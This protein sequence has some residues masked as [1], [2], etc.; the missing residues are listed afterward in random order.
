[1]EFFQN[2]I[3]E[4]DIIIYQDIGP[5][6]V[7]AVNFNNKQYFYNPEDWKVEESYKAYSPQMKVH[8]TKEFAKNL[9]GRIWIIDTKDTCL[10]DELFDK[11]EYEEIINKEFITNYYEEYL[12]KIKLIKK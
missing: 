3:Q 10:S 5:G 8:I 11:E 1:M 2:N 6:A 4:S 7:I 9:T 12:Y